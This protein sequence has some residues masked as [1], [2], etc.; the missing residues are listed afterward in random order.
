MIATL[1]AAVALNQMP[2][3][4]LEA[5]VDAA[6]QEYR[7]CSMNIRECG[8]VIYRWREPG[9]TRVWYF[10][11]KP[12]TSNKAY[13]VTINALA[14][15]APKGFEKIADAH[16]HICSIHNKP[17]AQ[18]FSEGDK[19]SNQGFHLVGYMLDL[20]TNLIHRYSPDDD[21]ADDEEV[22]MS[23]GRV[24]YLTTGHLAGALSVAPATIDRPIDDNL[25][26]V[27][28]LRDYLLRYQETSK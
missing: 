15:D 20:C 12:E 5:A 22:D 19:L 4:T 23:S 7:A 25:D 21:D 1:A 27:N 3:P 18:F 11:E 8:G 9:S 26:G 24:F 2:Y 6:L 17:F 10:Y 16:I 13:G 28:K 14:E